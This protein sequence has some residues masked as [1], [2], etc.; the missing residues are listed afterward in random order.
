MWW[1]S[2]ESN[3]SLTN[4]LVRKCYQMSWKFC[5]QHVNNSSAQ[6]WNLE[7]FWGTLK[8]SE[9]LWGTQGLGP[10]FYCS[11][12]QLQDWYVHNWKWKFILY[13]FISSFFSHTSEDIIVTPFA[14]ILA[15]LRNVRKNYTHLTGLPQ[16]LHKYVFI[17]IYL[18]KYYCIY[19]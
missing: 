13:D 15:S 11:R 1:Y 4:V 8:N 9:E 14:Q 16:N 5:D 10:D 19:L 2:P 18:A 12:V 7:E 6:L 17:C 3:E